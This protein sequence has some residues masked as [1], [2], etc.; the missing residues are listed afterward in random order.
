MPMIYEVLNV[1]KKLQNTIV[2]VRVKC[3]YPIGLSRNLQAL[4]KSEEQK[5]A[6]SYFALKP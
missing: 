5:Q 3:N 6:W 2:Y 1:S 4:K